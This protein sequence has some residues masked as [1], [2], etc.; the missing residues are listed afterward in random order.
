MAPQL[1]I[2]PQEALRDFDSVVCELHWLSARVD[3][4]EGT[5]VA[6]TFGRYVQEGGGP[7]PLEI[8]VVAIW[9]RH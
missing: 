2:T 6:M 5:P 8:V 9:D 4:E 7:E 3:K 1:L